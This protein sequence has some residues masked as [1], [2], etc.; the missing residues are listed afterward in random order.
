MSRTGAIAKIHVAKK[1]LG[2]DDATYRAVLHRVTGQDSAARLNDVQLGNV[3]REFVRLGWKDGGA[4]LRFGR[5]PTGRLIRILWRDVA[6][7]KSETALRSMIRRILGLA[8]EVIPEPDMLSVADASKVVE[9][10]KA[11]QR[12]RAGAR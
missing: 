6:R 3:I 8:E 12:R 5:T 7:E 10:L 1:Q 2:L 4:E 9:A 11:M